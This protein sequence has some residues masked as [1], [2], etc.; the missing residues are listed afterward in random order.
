M[1]NDHQPLSWCKA[2]SKPLRQMYVA[3]EASV[4]AAGD[5]DRN[6]SISSALSYWFWILNLF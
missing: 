3:G 4:V 1:S 6:Q 2:S 5:S